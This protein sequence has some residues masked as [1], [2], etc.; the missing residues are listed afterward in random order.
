[1]E[2]TLVPDNVLTKRYSL[3]WASRTGGRTLESCLPYE[4]VEREAR[5]RSL[6]VPEFVDAFEIE[7]LYNGVPGLMLRF[8]SKT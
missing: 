2:S 8:V 6:T 5:R 3:R 1:M 4:V 7:F